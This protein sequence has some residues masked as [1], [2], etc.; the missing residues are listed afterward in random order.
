M[1]WY[2][3][4][5]ILVLTMI[6]SHNFATIGQLRGTTLIQLLIQ[7]KFDFSYVHEDMLKLKEVKVCW[8]IEKF[9]II[10]NFYLL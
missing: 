10:S 5:T 6:L 9:N 8:T 2:L 1:F 4:W 3:S 7:F